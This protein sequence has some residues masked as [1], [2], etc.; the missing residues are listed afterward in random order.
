MFILPSG[1]CVNDILRSTF[2]IHFNN[3]SP[4]ICILSHVLT[5]M[6]LKTSQRNAVTKHIIFLVMFKI[7]L[8]F[9]WRSFTIRG[10]FCYV[11][12]VKERFQAILHTTV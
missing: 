12:G 1:K 2:Q 8:S 10:G 9:K 6:I 4:T 5:G 11:S 3:L 7:K